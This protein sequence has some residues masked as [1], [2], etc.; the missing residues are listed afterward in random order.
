MN[1][2]EKLSFG[3]RDSHQNYWV[4]QILFAIKL[5]KQKLSRNDEVSSV[6]M[7]AQTTRKRKRQ[8]YQLLRKSVAGEFPI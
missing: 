1:Y 8:V 4:L 3:Q 6:D 7:A 5:I 2:L